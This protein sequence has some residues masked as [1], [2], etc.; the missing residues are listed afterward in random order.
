MKTQSTSMM[1][2]TE[3]KAKAMVRVILRRL[4]ETWGGAGDVLYLR[5]AE[6]AQRTQAAEEAHVRL[7]LCL[8]PGDA[9]DEEADDAADD[10]GGIEAVGAHVLPQG[11]GH[12]LEERL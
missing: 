4:G 8:G 10:Q 2:H 11:V 1:L 7:V 6:D 12:G 3:G 9:D 5:E